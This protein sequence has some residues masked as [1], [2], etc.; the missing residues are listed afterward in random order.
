MLLTHESR[1][2]P[3]RIRIMQIGED[4]NPEVGF[5]DRVGYRH[6]EINQERIFRFP[7][8]SW[9]RESNPHVTYR[10]YEDFD[11]FLETGYLHMDAEL[12][13][14]GGGRFGPEID[15][16]QEGLREPFEVAPDVFIPAGS[17]KW[18][19]NAWDFG[20]DPSRPIS[21]SGR[22]EL[23]GFY[24]GHRYGGNVTVTARRGETL[25]SSLL[26]D[27]NIVRL[28]AGDFETTLLGLRLAWFFSPDVFVQSLF[29]YS[30]Q[31]D[32]WSANVRFAWLSTAGTGLYV[33][34]NDSRN[35][36]RLG[37]F[38]SPIHRGLIVKYARQIRLF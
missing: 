37:R 3:G 16:S 21:F 30:D 1:V 2:W 34:Y 31:I 38:G 32:V 13:F 14:E 36:E 11:G 29:Q 5:V 20:I 27:H 19:V 9:L 6:I 12:K 7:H 26:V 15:V 10:R 25:S 17:Y 22:A 4:F 23:G 28:P 8:V 33:V 18:T 24:D 35:A